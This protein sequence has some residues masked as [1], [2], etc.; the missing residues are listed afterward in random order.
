VSRQAVHCSTR[1]WPSLTAVSMQRPARTGRRSALAAAR[2]QRR[3]PYEASSVVQSHHAL[4]TQPVAHRSGPHEEAGAVP[5]GA[6][7]AV[8]PLQDVQLARS[9]GSDADAAVKRTAQLVQLNYPRER[10]QPRGCGA[11]SRVD[12]ATVCQ[13]PPHQGHSTALLRRQNCCGRRRGAP[14]ARLVP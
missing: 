9:R 8:S 4:R 5:Q 10:E 11:R 14:W 1:C 2:A 7:V 6:P 3:T 12:G 13:Q